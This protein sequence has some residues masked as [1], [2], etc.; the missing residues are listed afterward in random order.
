MKRVFV[1]GVLILGVGAAA[2]AGPLS[3]YT[4]FCARFDKTD[5]IVFDTVVDLDY[6]LSSFNFGVTAV[7]DLASFDDL[8]FTA[9]GTLGTFE[10]RSMLDFEPQSPTFMAW[11]GAA[12]ITLGGATLFGVFAFD[13]LAMPPTSNLGVGATLGMYGTAGNVTLTATTVFN[14]Y[15]FTGLYHYYGYDWMVTLDAL[16]WCGEWFVPS[17]YTYGVVASNCDLAWSGASIYA[18]FPL[19]CLCVTAYGRFSCTG[20]GGFGFDISGI[21]TGIPWLTI[22]AVSIGFNITS[23]TVSTY[24]EFAYDDFVCVTPYFSLDGDQWHSPWKVE[25]ITL[26]ALMLA[27]SDNGV[28]VKAGEIFDDTWLSWYMN[29][30]VQWGFT[31]SGELAVHGMI[32]PYTSDDCIYDSDYDE[33]FGIWIDGASCCGGAYEIG[34][35]S[36]FDTTQTGVLFDWAETVADFEIGI[37]ANMALGFS[38]SVKAGGLQWFQL[39]GTF[40]F[41]AQGEG[42][43]SLRSRPDGACAPS[44]PRGGGL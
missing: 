27:Y 5:L 2:F 25:G 11:T 21:E 30:G 40:S 24:W 32:D 17:G 20:F 19:A 26:N 31:L 12:R 22:R 4:E 1:L 8:F 3:G 41:G 42:A 15:D 36:F 33:F 35:I 37:G 7:F 18:D 6:T 14:M 9:A 28:T 44:L 29:S 16:K 43:P 38:L 34:L 39:C 13:N 10:L 23:K